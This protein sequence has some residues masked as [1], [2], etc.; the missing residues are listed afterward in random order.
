MPQNGE[1]KTMTMLDKVKFF[2]DFAFELLLG[3]LYAV[4]CM[5]LL[6]AGIGA[7]VGIMVR[8]VEFFAGG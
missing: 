8:V 1:N 5:V 6:G 4:A 7:A 3:L 2:R